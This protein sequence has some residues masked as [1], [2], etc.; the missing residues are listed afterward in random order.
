MLL[1]AA[2]RSHKGFRRDRA[3]PD[4]RFEELTRAPRTA[5]EERPGRESPCVRDGT[6]ATEVVSVEMTA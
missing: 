2:R 5:G 3:L 1:R 6:I 4:P